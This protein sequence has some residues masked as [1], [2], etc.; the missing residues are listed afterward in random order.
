MSLTTKVTSHISCYFIETN[1]PNEMHKSFN[2]TRSPS[3]QGSS[4]VGDYLLF[5][6]QSLQCI[7]QAPW[8]HF[9]FQSTAKSLAHYPGKTF[10]S[11]LG[12]ESKPLLFRGSVGTVLKFRIQYPRLCHHTLSTYHF[13]YPILS[14]PSG[15]GCLSQCSNIFSE[16][17]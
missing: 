2:V 17:A 3:G 9:Y 7:C 1:S 13:V 5:S 11:S 16:T 15:I 6:M 14:T 8:G 4:M 12:M 10:M